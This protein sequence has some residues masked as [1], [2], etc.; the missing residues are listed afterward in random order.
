MHGSS[1]PRTGG[2]RPYT[3]AYLLYPNVITLTCQLLAGEVPRHVALLR[4]VPQ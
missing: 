2:Q 4:A 1:V 3:P